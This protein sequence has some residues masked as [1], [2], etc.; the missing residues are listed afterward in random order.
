VRA[1][2]SNSAGT[3]YG[4]EVSFST[5][6]ADPEVITQQVSNITST[7]ADI[8]GE[9]IFD[10]ICLGGF[11]FCLSTSPLPTVNDIIID[12]QGGE[13]PIFT[14][15]PSDFGITLQ[16]NTTYYVRSYAGSYCYGLGVVYGNELSFTTLP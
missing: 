9:I 13:Y 12:E 10:G 5:P 11:G 1:Y 3:A 6:S 2:A 16:S 4:N 15:N 7:S 14:I 8:T